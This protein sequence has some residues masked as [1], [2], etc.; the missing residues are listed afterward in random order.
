MMFKKKSKNQS[1]NSSPTVSTHNVDAT[2]A[3]ITSDVVISAQKSGKKSIRVLFWRWCI[4]P[5]LIVF[6]VFHLLV[7]SLLLMW[8]TYPVTNSMFMLSHRLSGGV[9]AQDWVDYDDIAKGAKQAAIASED[10]KF[11]VHNGFDIDGIER[12]MK[13]NEKSGVVSVGGSTITQQLA[14][15]LFLTSHRSYIRKAEEAIITMMIENMWD[16]KRI[17]EVYLNIAEFG[18]G[19]YGIQAASKHYFNKSAKSLSNEQAALLISMLPNPKYYQKNRNDKRL[20]NKQRIIMAR[21]P[22]A[23]LPK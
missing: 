20:K 18:K 21:M 11:I 17:L 22:S 23:H 3:S 12:A 2:G 5:L 7:A 8:Q 19:I 13:M 10:A 15:N 9:V 1:I 6:I 4:A 14:K 16:K